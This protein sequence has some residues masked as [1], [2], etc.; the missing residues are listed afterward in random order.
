M[1]A[2][3]N[4]DHLVTSET[5]LSH[6]ATVS[7]TWQQLVTSGNSWSHGHTCQ[8]LVPPGNSWSHLATAGHTQSHLSKAGHTLQQLVPP[9]NSWSHLATAGHIWSQL[10]PP[11]HIWNQ[12]VTPGNSWSHYLLIAGGEGGGGERRL[13]DL[14]ALPQV[15]IHN[16]YFINIDCA[17][18][19]TRTQ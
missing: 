8:K 3:H 15:K 1:T 5:S 2:G 10:W 16:N 11:G 9:C 17:L 14:L 4:F 6:M 18:V 13:V 19:L 7:C 12:F